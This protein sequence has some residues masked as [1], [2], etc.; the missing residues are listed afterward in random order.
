MTSRY[1]L[2]GADP[3]PALLREN[4]DEV[5][6]HGC[7]RT[8]RLWR[9]IADAHERRAAEFRGENTEGVRP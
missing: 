8:A 4:A 2:K 1:E 6:R 7:E 3:W 9:Q 5:A